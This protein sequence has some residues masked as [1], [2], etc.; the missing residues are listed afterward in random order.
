M[1]LISA[2][3]TNKAVP[4]LPTFAKLLCQKRENKLILDETNVHCK[5]STSIFVRSTAHC[6]IPDKK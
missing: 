6:V 2:R 4:I 3:I 1:I 5:H